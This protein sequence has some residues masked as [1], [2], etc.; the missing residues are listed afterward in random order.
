MTASSSATAVASAPD[1]SPGTSLYGDIVEFLYHEAE[2]LDAYRFDEW[3][4][5]LA[6]DIYYVMPV[7]TTQFR[8]TGAGFHEVAF[9]DENLISLRTRV[10]RL[11]TEFAWAET[12]PSRTRHFVTNVLVEAG[13]ASN[14]FAVR[15]NFMVTRTRADHGY[16]MFVGR[17]EDVL[18]RDDANGLKL[19]RRR[20]LVDETVITGTNL[21]ILF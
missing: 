8:A 9:F 2:L 16:Q 3:L 20:I 15:S 1:C 18:R 7:R 10:Q 6:D 21:S 5:L 17:R 4:A 12:P 14:E 11:Q 19:A 13:E